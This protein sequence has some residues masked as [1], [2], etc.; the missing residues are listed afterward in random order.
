MKVL[1]YPKILIFSPEAI[2]LYFSLSNL[3]TL[4]FKLFALFIDIPLRSQPESTI[5][6]LIILL[7]FASHL[8]LYQL[9]ERFL[10]WSK[11][12]VFFKKRSYSFF[13]VS[14]SLLIIV[15]S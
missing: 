7:I 11:D 1:T 4:R 9:L 2:I 3:I 8:Q 6:F 5:I 12:L 14:Y 10:Y 13:K 15:R